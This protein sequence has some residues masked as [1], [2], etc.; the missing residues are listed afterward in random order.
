[1]LSLNFKL[2]FDNLALIQPNITIWQQI[3][4][5][6]GALKIVRKINL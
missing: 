4:L 1:M 2:E 6:F 5:N 3:D